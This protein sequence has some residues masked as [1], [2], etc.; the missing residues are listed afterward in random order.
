MSADFNLTDLPRKRDNS[1]WPSFK[2]ALKS[3]GLFVL[4]GTLSG[5][6]LVVMGELL[7]R[8]GKWERIPSLSLEHVGLGL[9]VSSIAVFGYEWRSHVK[10]VVDLSEELQ[11]SIKDVARIRQEL[12]TKHGE[13]LLDPSLRVYLGEDNKSL[14]RTLI[15]FV[16]A[17]S[18]IQDEEEQDEFRVNDG[19]IM[20]LKKKY[21]G[22]MERLFR[23]FVLTNALQFQ[24]VVGGGEGHF[25]VPP[26]PEELADMI[27]AAQMSTMVKN[28]GYDVVSDIPSWRDDRL[29]SFKRVS[30]VQIRKGVKVRRVFNLFKH[31]PPNPN[32][33]SYKEECNKTIKTLRDHL[34]SSTLL[35]KWT[36]HKGYEVRVFWENELER[37]RDAG[38]D[39]EDDEF[40]EAH[41]GLFKQYKEPEKIIRY[42]VRR[43]NLS[44]MLLNWDPDG[45]ER[46]IDL[47]GLMWRKASP[48]D[49]KVI[50]EIESR[51]TAQIREPEVKTEIKQTQNTV[52]EITR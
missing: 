5:L 7:S 48:L 6:L 46:D 27:L 3:H 16:E 29:K 28:D 26:T 33:A 8:P 42:N 51:W 11:R 45:I 34:E 2:R 20:D 31:G 24:K 10:Q 25:K 41:F 32:S 23:R 4:G 50:K 52:Q 9:I 15:E 13:Q 44:D 37:T 14:C 1:G 36:I 38:H 49:E 18:E 17:V 19:Y 43:E 21:I 30:I 22:V 35:S 12:R 47:F 39:F 40:R